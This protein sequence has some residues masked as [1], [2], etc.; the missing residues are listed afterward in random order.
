[1]SEFRSNVETKYHGSRFPV[2]GSVGTLKAGNLDVI[3][4]LRDCFVLLV[5]L[6]RIL[7]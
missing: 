2:Y 7:L 6:L 4:L 5:L 1:M 3:G